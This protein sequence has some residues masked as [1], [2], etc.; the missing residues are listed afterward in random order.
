[1]IEIRFSTMPSHRLMPYSIPP[2]IR[3][4]KR[5]VEVGQSRFIDR[6]P[7]GNDPYDAGF[8]GDGS[9]HVVKKPSRVNRGPKPFDEYIGPVDVVEGERLGDKLFV[10]AQLRGVIINGEFVPQPA[11]TPKDPLVLAAKARIGLQEG[12]FAVLADGN[13]LRMRVGNAAGPLQEVSVKMPSYDPN[14]L[15]VE[16]RNSLV[17]ASA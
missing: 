10:T 8:N 13:L 15:V 1:M 2:N 4:E 12:F 5:L 3:G 6:K 17:I 14:K 7:A 9:R 11:K 16:Y